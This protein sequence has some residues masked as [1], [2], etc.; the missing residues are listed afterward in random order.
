MGD[1]AEGK[2]G[3]RERG[4][5]EGLDGRAVTERQ[6]HRQTG[7]KGLGGWEGGRERESE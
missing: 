1:K 4:G 3:G 5:G 2:G 6:T 7:A